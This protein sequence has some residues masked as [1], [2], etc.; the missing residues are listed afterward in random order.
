MWPDIEA[1][2]DE[3]TR[4]LQNLI[5]NA[6]KYHPADRQPRVVVRGSVTDSVFRVEVEDNGIGIDPTQISRLFHVFSRLQARSRHEGVGVGLALCRK[7]V[8]HHHGQ[9]G[10]T[11]A[12]E[13]LGCTFWFEL[14]LKVA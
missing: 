12:G 5:G 11:S 8:E 14:P 13:G 2:P 4:L 3:M 10:V 9:I 7:I 1:N 6:L